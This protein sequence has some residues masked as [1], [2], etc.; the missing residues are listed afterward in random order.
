M[1]KIDQV[2]VHIENA[3]QILAGEFY[4][5]EELKK[6]SKRLA[7]VWNEMT[8]G[9]YKTSP[10]LKWYKSKSNGLII[11]GPV[12]SSFFCIH[13]LLPSLIK[14]LIGYVP[15]GYVI[16]LSK[17]T[18]NVIWASKRFTLQEDLTE[19]I[20]DIFWDVSI[21]HRPKGLIVAITGDHLC[22]KIRGIKQK[23]FT[24]TIKKRGALSEQDI[25]LFMKYLEKVKEGI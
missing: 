9:I 7:K 11:K 23:S 13:H 2:S 21:L 10:A 20:A 4:D 14:V 25:S 19:L 18:R 17:I 3:L 15:N 24:F 1:N 16:G 12:D 22:E 6:T 8:E 5:T